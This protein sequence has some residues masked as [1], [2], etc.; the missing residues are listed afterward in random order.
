MFFD[1]CFYDY[2]VGYSRE[3]VGNFIS[4]GQDELKRM[5]LKSQIIIIGKISLVENQRNT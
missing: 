5:I 3:L 1:T 2:L 4:I